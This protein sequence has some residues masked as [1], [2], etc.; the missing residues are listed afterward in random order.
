MKIVLIIINNVN[1]IYLRKML[2][3]IKNNVKKDIVVFLYFNIYKCI[4]CS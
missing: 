1:K 4:N 2:L 3:K